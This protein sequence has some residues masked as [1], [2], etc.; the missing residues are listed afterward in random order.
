MDWT[1]TVRKGDL[2][3]IYEVSAERYYQAKVA[4]ITLFLKENKIPGKPYIYLTSKKNELEV[5]VKTK[6]DRRVGERPM[7]SNEYFMEQI[8][9]LLTSIRTSNLVDTC[10]DEASKFLQ[11][12]KEVISVG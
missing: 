2:S 4:G 8:D 6:V 1:V 5:E 9:N 12:A 3:G 10:K 7:S 11:R